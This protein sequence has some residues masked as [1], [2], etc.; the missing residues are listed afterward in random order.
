MSL[1]HPK[2]TDKVCLVD[3]DRCVFR[4]KK[5]R[6]L[7]KDI[8]ETSIEISGLSGMYCMEP[9]VLKAISSRLE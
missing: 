4:S 6:F 2:G 7:R 8:P 3:G 1:D 5:V 9:H